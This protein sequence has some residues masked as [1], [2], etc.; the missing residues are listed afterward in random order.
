MCMY[1]CSRGEGGRREGRDEML[2]LYIHTHI[3]YVG[4]MKFLKAREVTT[5]EQANNLCIQ[6]KVLLR[7]GRI[8]LMPLTP[9]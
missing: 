9:A 2:I 5:S 7:I 4:K 8:K 3:T 6:P 1:K